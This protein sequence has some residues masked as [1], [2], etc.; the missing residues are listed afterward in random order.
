MGGEEQLSLLPL[1]GP[2]GDLALVVLPETNTRMRLRV[3]EFAGDGVTS[4]AR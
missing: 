1:K 2:R 3:C 4:R